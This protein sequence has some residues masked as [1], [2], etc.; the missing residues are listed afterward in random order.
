MHFT[1][2]DMTYDPRRDGSLPTLDGKP[3][4]TLKDAIKLLKRDPK[5]K[6]NV[7]FSFRKPADPSLIITL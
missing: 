2:G 4:A 5:V 1:N 7:T 3:C 6:A